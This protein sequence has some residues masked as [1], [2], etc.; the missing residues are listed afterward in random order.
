MIRPLS[1][2]SCYIFSIDLAFQEIVNILD[3]DPITV[4]IYADDGICLKDNL[5]WQSPAISE[6]EWTTYEFSIQP[7]YE[8]TDLVLGFMVLPFGDI[9]YWITL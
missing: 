4:K 7:D 1:P 9:F 8:Y 3:M 5:L 6:E 2:D